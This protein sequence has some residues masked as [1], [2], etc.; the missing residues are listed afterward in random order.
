MVPN[1]LHTS[2]GYVIPPLLGFIVLLGLALISLLQ[3]GRKRTNIL[4]AGICFLGALLNADMALVSILPDERTRPPRRPDGPFLLRLQRP[5]LYRLR[6]CLS[7]ASATDSGW[8]SPRGSSVI[9]FLTIVPTDLYFNGYHYYFF[10]RIARTGMLFH[11]FSATVAFTVLYCLVAPL[12]R[13]AAD[14]RQ[15]QEKQDQVYLRR[16]GIFRPPA[17]FDD[18]SGQR[19]SRLPARDISASSPVFFSLSAS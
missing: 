14:R 3:G 13:H 2:W 19:R 7:R 6:A 5:R 10:G 16:A 11:L 8:R 1:G 15:S 4:F 9:A 12:S 17:C 18:P